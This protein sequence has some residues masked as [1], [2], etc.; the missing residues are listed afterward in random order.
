[1]LINTE[2][3]DVL[4]Y[5]SAGQNQITSKASSAKLNR[6][7]I[8]FKTLNIFK[9]GFYSRNEEVQLACGMLFN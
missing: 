5:G 6:G 2:K 4:S 7:K 8:L 1:M 3:K 9:N